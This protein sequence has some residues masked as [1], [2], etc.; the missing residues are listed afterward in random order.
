M[1]CRWCSD[2]AVKAV[3]VSEGRAPA[4][5]KHAVTQQDHRRVVVVRAC[6]KHLHKLPR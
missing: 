4:D 6:L 5:P 3:T 1:K 2:S